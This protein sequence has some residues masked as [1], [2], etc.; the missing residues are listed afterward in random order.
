MQRHRHQEFIRFLN[1]IERTI[2]AGKAIHAIVDSYAT[3]KHVTDDWSGYGSLRTRG[4][5]HHVI[6]E[7]DD[8][9][10]AEE[11]MPIIHPVFNN[12]KNW[13]NGIHHGVS[14]KHL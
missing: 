11:F 10:V 14:P 7:C 12:M 2:P 13:L 5:D 1:E 8:P 6:A 4:Y 3:H 9:E